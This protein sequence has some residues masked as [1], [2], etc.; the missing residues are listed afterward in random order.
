MAGQTTSDASVGR[1][2]QLIAN[3]TSWRRR[4]VNG[5]GSQE[6]F[7]LIG[8]VVSEDVAE[9][10]RCRRNPLGLRRFTPTPAHDFQRCR[11]KKE[12]LFIPCVFAGLTRFRDMY[13]SGQGV[14]T[15]IPGLHRAHHDLAAF[16]SHTAV[17]DLSTMRCCHRPILPR[18]WR[19][20]KA[21]YHTPQ[22]A[23]RYVRKV[24]I[25]IHDVDHHLGNL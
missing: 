13:T 25:C 5:G 4:I 14:G 20:Y 19:S 18:F 24:D 21:R 15:E 3:P 7:A 16:R 2:N 9:V 11:R 6:A 8:G 1:L 22:T 17:N 23:G 10:F 12:P